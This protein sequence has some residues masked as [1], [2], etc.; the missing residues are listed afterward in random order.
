MKKILFPYRFKNLNDIFKNP[1]KNPKEFMYGMYEL[2]KKNNYDIDYLL[3]PKGKDNFKRL[4]FI[5]SY[6]LLYFRRNNYKRR[7]V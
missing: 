7:F 3:E 5:G 6:F 1:E 2:R 4:L